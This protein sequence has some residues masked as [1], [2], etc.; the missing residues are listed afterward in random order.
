MMTLLTA[1]F[2][3]WLVI[4]ILLVAMWLLRRQDRR[5]GHSHEEDALLEDDDPTRTDAGDDVDTTTSGEGGAGA[6]EPNGDAGRGRTT[7]GD[8][9]H[10]VT[11]GGTDTDTIEEAPPNGLRTATIMDHFEGID[12]PF[13]LAPATGRILNSEHH[14]IFVSSHGDAEAVGTAFADELVRLGFTVEPAGF[15]Q[16]LATREDTV[17]SLRISPSAGTVKSDDGKSPRYPGARRG[18]VAI[19]IWTGK[20]EPPPLV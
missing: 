7:D 15:D 4:T 3:L 18:D 6:E 11:S 12:L 10:Q 5:R 2:Y 1:L 8:P 20:G 17:L 14:A 16:A 13:D 9:R 19:E